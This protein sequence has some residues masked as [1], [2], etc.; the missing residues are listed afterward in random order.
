LPHTN[1][2][3]FTHVSM[4]SLD[5]YESHVPHRRGGRNGG[6]LGKMR[7]LVGKVSP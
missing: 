7:R 3:D 2:F 6:A 5:T 1:K 4:S